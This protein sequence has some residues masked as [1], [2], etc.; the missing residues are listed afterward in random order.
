MLDNNKKIPQTCI[1]GV[2]QV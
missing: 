2:T 1:E